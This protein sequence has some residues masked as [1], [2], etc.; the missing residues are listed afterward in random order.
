MSDGETFFKEDTND[1]KIV[2]APQQNL[3]WK[4]VEA[5]SI[6]LPVMVWENKRFLI[7]SDHLRFNDWDQRERV[8]F[9]QR[10]C[11]LF[12]HDVNGKITGFDGMIQLWRHRMPEENL[13]KE[14]LILLEQSVHHL[15]RLNLLM[16]AGTDLNK[17][18]EFQIENV[19]SLLDGLTQ[20]VLG[21]MQPIEVSGLSL[22]KGSAGYVLFLIW[23]FLSLI[24]SLSTQRSEWR[25]TLGPGNRRNRDLELC[26]QSQ[27]LPKILNVMEDFPQHSRF[28]RWM[29]M[30]CASGDILD[31][32]EHEWSFSFQMKQKESLI[33]QFSI[34]S[35]N[36]MSELFY[37][38]LIGKK[39]II[40]EEKIKELKFFS[41]IEILF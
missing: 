5:S 17:V 37:S 16:D 13:F 25:I 38:S 30:R 23:S 27:G 15:K 34:G 3:G 1:G 36:W 32:N 33:D 28:N 31:S 29:M 6:W 18:S 40:S 11:R 22:V 21:V 10:L 39:P 14:D 2:L 26:I 41:A 9:L 20:R 35:E 12:Y 24:A 7:L 8:D 4:W 19:V